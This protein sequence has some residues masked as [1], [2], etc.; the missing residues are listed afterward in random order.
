MDE[1]L[2]KVISIM[3][4]NLDRELTINDFAAAASLSPSHLAH[5]FKQE[6]GEPL[7]RYLRGLR[8]ERGRELLETTFFSVQQ[9]ATRVGQSSNHFNANFKKAH[10]ITPGQFAARNRRPS[11]A[12]PK[13]RTQ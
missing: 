6:T 3:N 5:L 7:I 1:R 11:R 13:R 9:I 10:G 12:E 4:A 2:R 8:M